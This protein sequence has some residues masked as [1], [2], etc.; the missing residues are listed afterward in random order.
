MNVI[1]QDETE[2][3]RVR[4][5]AGITS[6]L[7]GITIDTSQIVQKTLLFN[8]DGITPCLSPSRTR[9][10]NVKVQLTS[11]TS[12]SNANAVL[13]YTFINFKV[14]RLKENKIVTLNGTKTVKNV[15]GSDWLSFLSGTATIKYQERSLNLQATF[16]GGSVANWN[17][18]RV[19]EC[20][21]RPSDQRITFKVN[22]NSTLEGFANV[23][24]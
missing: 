1:V 8:F 4:K 24:L 22:G 10:G 23:D 11:G 20:S 15:N 13:T 16:N 17:V 18:A 6:D 9:A 19:T 2:F 12:W 3:G 7:C 21:Y 5:S 14:V